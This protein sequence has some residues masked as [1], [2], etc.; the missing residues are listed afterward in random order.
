MTEKK[1]QSQPED[2]IINDIVERTRL[3]SSRNGVNLGVSL[4]PAAAC[5][6]AASTNGAKP[7]AGVGATVFFVVGLA[8]GEDD[9][10]SPPSMKGTKPFDGAGAFE[11]EETAFLTVV[12]AGGRDSTSSESSTKGTKPPA[13]LLLDTFLAGVA[14]DAP[15]AGSRNG[16]ILDDDPAP[17]PAPPRTCSSGNPLRLPGLFDR[18]AHHLLHLGRVLLD[19]AL[20]RAEVVPL[21][22]GGFGS[23]CLITRR[24]NE[25]L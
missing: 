16:T 21:V 12:R 17:T 18:R 24:V 15:G 25:D 8:A 23:G 14:S 20:A 2:Q 5:S 1:G 6:G 11:E 4:G 7:R 22:H 9:S 13:G 3:T 19:T 10:S